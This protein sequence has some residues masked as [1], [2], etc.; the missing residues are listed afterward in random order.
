[1]IKAGILFSDPCLELECSDAGSCASVQ[2]AGAG[3]VETVA[4]ILFEI[5]GFSPEPRLWAC[6]HLT[7]FVGS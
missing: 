4:F 2:L 3:F 6:L 5:L 1:M 7:A